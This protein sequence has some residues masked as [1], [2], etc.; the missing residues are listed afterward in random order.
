M[1]WSDSTGDGYQNDC[2]RNSLMISGL[3]RALVFRQEPYLELAAANLF[4]QS[5]ER[6]KGRFNLPSTRG[7][8]RF[9]D[10]IMKV[11]LLCWRSLKACSL[12]RCSICTL[13]PDQTSWLEKALQSKQSLINSSGV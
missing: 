8:G 13:F 10:S 11:N 6:G 3:A 1:A 5:V 2:I 12:K 4:R 7:G 9:K